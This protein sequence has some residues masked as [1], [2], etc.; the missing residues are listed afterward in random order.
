MEERSKITR[1]GALRPAP[2]SLLGCRSETRVFK[3]NANQ[4]G[5]LMP[6]VRAFHSNNRPTSHQKSSFSIVF[7]EKL[8]LPP[9]RACRQASRQST[10]YIVSLSTH[11]ATTL[12]NNKHQHGSRAELPRLLLPLQTRLKSLLRR[13]CKGRTGC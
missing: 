8:Q 4:A 12:A 5:H 10:D 3:H 1:R 2:A 7:G 6:Y 13:R 11:G 9:Q